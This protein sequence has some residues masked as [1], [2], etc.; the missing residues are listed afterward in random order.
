ML[1]LYNIILNLYNIMLSIYCQ[2]IIPKTSVFLDMQNCVRIYRIS[3]FSIELQNFR[4]KCEIKS[5]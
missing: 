5:L 2:L 3:D 1:Y 4:F